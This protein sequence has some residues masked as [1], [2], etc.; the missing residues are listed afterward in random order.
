MTSDEGGA[1]PPSDLE[2]TKQTPRPTGLQGQKPGNRRVR[3]ERTRSEYFRY[4]PSGALEARPKAH[5]E[6]ETRD[7]AVRYAA[8]PA[9]DYRFEVWCKSAQGVWSAAPAT[10]AFLVEGPEGVWWQ[11]WW[12]RGGAVIVLVALF[13]TWILLRRRSRG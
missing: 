13:L 2:R 7:R 1:T 10:F 3:V 11:D 8:L 12:V 6:V 5:E 4:T 9:G